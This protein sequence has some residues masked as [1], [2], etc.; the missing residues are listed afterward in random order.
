MD[1][2]FN[3]NLLKIHRDFAAF[4]IEQHDFLI[5]HSADQIFD[6]LISIGGKYKK[7]LDLGARN[8]FLTAKLMNHCRGSDI[9]ATDIS[10]NMLSL[11]PS[12]NKVVL[13]EENIALDERFDLI[14]SVLNLH[15]INNLPE[16]LKSMKSH[17]TQ[18]GLFIFSMFC[19]PSLKNLRYRIVQCESEVAAISSPHI[20][21]F[22]DPK[23]IYILLQNAGFKFIIEDIENIEL[24]Y[25]SPLHLMKELKG[26]GESNNLSLAHNIIS[27]NVRAKLMND[28]SVFIDN[29]Q[30]VTVV[31]R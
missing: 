9:F 7:I 8:G 30:I 23:D 22:V 12:Y 13:D 10:H 18:D 15:W 16:F 25:N 6:H 19:G 3:R 2:I 27:K 14:T 5:K 28:D 1:K 24:E 21:P 11:N 4:K 29:V 26:M 17:L 31:S 20:S